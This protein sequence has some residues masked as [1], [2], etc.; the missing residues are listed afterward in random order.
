MHRNKVLQHLFTHISSAQQIYPV[1]FL[2]G[3]SLASH[4]YFQDHKGHRITQLMQYILDFCPEVR[5]ERTKCLILYAARLS[6]IILLGFI[7]ISFSYPHKWIT[8][9]FH[10]CQRFSGLRML[11]NTKSPAF[12]YLSSP[13]VNICAPFLS[14]TIGAD[15]ST[16]MARP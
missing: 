13:S 16:F 9:S 14:H 1:P 12:F 2:A 8:H 7:L 10:R 4:Y 11:L 5:R 15:L 6:R 3:L